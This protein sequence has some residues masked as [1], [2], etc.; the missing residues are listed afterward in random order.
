[1]RNTLIPLALLAIAT[2]ASAG[3]RPS[4]YEG[5]RYEDPDAAVDYANR[6]GCVLPQAVAPSFNNNA[7]SIEM[8]RIATVR[9]RQ[10][11]NRNGDRMSP[12]C[13]SEHDPRELTG[14][15][16]MGEPAEVPQD[17]VDDIAAAEAPPQD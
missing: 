3:D 5:A 17:E 14:E 8:S 9:V 1:M 4:R 6:E 11:A 13:G 12:I 7:A 15:K 16:T 2:T 10:A